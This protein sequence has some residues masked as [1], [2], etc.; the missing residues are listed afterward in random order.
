MVKTPVVVGYFRPAV[1]LPLCVVTGLPDVQLELILAHELAHIRRHDYL[2][3]VLQT[4]VETLFFYHPAVWWLSRQIRNERENCCDDVAMATV[5]SR[6]DYGRALLAIEELRAAPT[7]LSLGA[8]G[9]SLLARIRRIAACEPVPSA[10]GGGSIL[11]A[12]LVSAAIVGAAT[13]G[14]APAERKPAADTGSASEV[15][16]NDIEPSA[17]RAITK[18]ENEPGQI[19]VELSGEATDQDGGRFHLV[20]G[21]TIW[22]GSDGAPIV[23]DE[24]D[25][26][27][28]NNWG[29]HT[30]VL[31]RH[32]EGFFDFY[33]QRTLQPG[34]G[35]MDVRRVEWESGQPAN[36][37]MPGAIDLPAYELL[38]QPSVQ[39]ALNLSEEQRTKL[40]DLSA[41][42]WLER[43]QIAGKELDEMESAK[44]AE[45]A[46][47]VAKA[48][49]GVVQSGHIGSSSPFSQEVVEKLERQWS[50]ARKQIE[51]ALAPEQLRTLK[52]LTF[53]TFAFGGGVMF[54]P[55]VLGR[56]GVAK[57]R[58]DE[59]RA[60]ELQLQKEKDRR[61]RGVTRERIKKMLAVL[62]SRQQ[63]QLRE[64]HSPDKNPETDCAMYPYPGL[65]SHMPDTG[66]AEELGFTA[67]QREHVRKI[68]TAHWMSLIALQQEEQKLPL[69]DEKAFKAIGEKR[70]QEMADL[71]KQIE[72]AL[73]PEQWASCREMAFQNLAMPTLRRVASI[74]QL[75]NKTGLTERL[76]MAVYIAKESVEMGLTEQQRAALREID[77]EYVDKPE[78]I[79]CELTDKALTAFTPAQQ[80]QLRAEVDR[81]GW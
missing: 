21:N 34:V 33:R 2:I 1:L 4:L 81:R 13:L 69:G 6:A 22:I 38:L 76:G 67:E 60:L 25:K 74:A 7:A 51:E 78:Q 14:A 39:Q 19:G 53:R 50:N 43:R 66:A 59:L 62:T 65:P 48:G 29:A 75:P 17:P 55:E 15:D 40:R 18:P 3:N 16:R 27:C 57:N 49:H 56:L 70:R 47:H 54:E 36:V 23:Y 10:I 35:R 79:Y 5:S 9:G 28:Y 24:Y 37:T 72:A 31:P 58:Q 71:R 46:V 20:R 44:Q 63:S 12:I 11:G 52:D 68:V 61:L 45:L 80:E 77:A 30:V 64:K 73:T 42:Y 8:R 26:N 32:T 41:K